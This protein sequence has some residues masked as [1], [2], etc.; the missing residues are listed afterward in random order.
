[1]ATRIR[2]RR[3]LIAIVAKTCKRTADASADTCQPLLALRSLLASVTLTYLN[4]DMV[5]SLGVAGNL[6][7]EPSLELSFL[8]VQ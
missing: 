6:V 3:A 5:E 8:R 2:E 1:M 4:L 7:L